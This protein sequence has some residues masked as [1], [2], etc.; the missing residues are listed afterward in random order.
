MGFKYNMNDI[1]A[2]IGLGN[3]SNM[4]ERI[5]KRRYIA[6]RYR[7]SFANIPGLKLLDLPIDYGH[8][9]WVFTIL[10]DRRDEFVKQMQKH[11]I[12]VSMV[13]GRIDK[14][15]IFGGVTP[16]LIGQE[17]FENHQIAIPVH[18]DLTDENVNLIMKQ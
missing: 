6:N 2:A 14:S 13:D 4:H 11:N 15:P 16:G 12:P 5:T 8:A 1:T 18:D 3:L 10:V 9:Y 17:E 7:E